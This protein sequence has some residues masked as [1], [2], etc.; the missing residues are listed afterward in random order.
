MKV[1][2]GIA[3]SP[4]V[5]SGP[6]LVLGSENFRIP[7]IY[8]H[9]DAVESELHRFHA[10]LQFVC[11]DIRGNE[12]LVTSQLGQQYGAIFSAHLQM[13]QDP[14]LINEVETL[15]RKECR[16]PESAVSRVLRGY[17]EQLQ[18]LGDRYLSER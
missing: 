11:N 8:V 15:I 4:G 3:V 7:S 2:N 1:F 9:H 17:A 12:E 16:S 14:R 18:K 6:V 5:V 10:A 13:A